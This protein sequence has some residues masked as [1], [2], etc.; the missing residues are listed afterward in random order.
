[1]KK[2]FLF[3]LLMPFLAITNASVFSNVL[4]CVS[5]N[6]YAY[7]SHMCQGLNRCTHEI[8]SVSLDE[9]KGVYGKNKAC[10]FCY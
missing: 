5:P 2:A 9:A 8:I 7:H 1:M 10:G 4:I 6:S 3:F